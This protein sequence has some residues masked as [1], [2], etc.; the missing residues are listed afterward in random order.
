MET[1]GTFEA[2]EA[3]TGHRPVMCPWRAFND[4]LVQRVYDVFSEREEGN[5]GWDGARPS[6]RLV[7]GVRFFS[8]ILN[9]IAEIQRDQDKKNAEANH[10]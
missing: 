3:M 5:L 7:K 2:V 1:E 6:H 10:G 8:R 4:P 9:R